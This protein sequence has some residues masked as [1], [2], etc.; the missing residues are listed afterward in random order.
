MFDPHAYFSI[1]IE[2]QHT[3]S[4]SYVSVKFPRALPELRGNE[5]IQ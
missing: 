2:I 1:I 4:L 5:K 3:N